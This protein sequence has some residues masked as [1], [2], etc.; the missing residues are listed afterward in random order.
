MIIITDVF[1][2][3]GEVGMSVRLIKVPDVR[4]GRGDPRSILATI[5]DIFN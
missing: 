3:R 4:R 5:M 1:H 2:S